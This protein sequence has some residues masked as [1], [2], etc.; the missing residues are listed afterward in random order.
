MKHEYVLRDYDGTA[1]VQRLLLST[2][3]TPPD[4]LMVY[5]NRHNRPAECRFRFHVTYM[6]NG[7]RTEKRFNIHARNWVSL[8]QTAK[9]IAEWLVRTHAC[10]M[11]EQIS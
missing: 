8:H 11:A 5:S 9:Q 2:G 6:M 10:L 7:N 3:A 1:E 4:N